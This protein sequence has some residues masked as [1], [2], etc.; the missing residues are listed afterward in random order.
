MIT[1]DRD[2]AA[3]D[4][5][6]ENISRFG[7]TRHLDELHRD[8]YT[9][10]KGA[11]DPET[12]ERART[13]IVRTVEKRT[14]RQIDPM[15]A[16]ADDYRGMDY[17]GYLLF[18]DPVF[19]EI[20]LNPRPLAL[21]TYLLGESC[22]LSSMGSHFR[23]PGGMPL[24]FHADY[25]PGSLMSHI[26]MV[27]NCNYALTPYCQETGALVMT[28]RS[29]LKKRQ[30]TDYEGWTSAGRTQAQIAAAK[31]PAEDLDAV[32]WEAPEGSVTLDIAP[33]DAVVFHGNTW[34]G[35][36][37]RSLPGIRAN[38]AVFMCRSNEVTQEL[39]GDQRYPDVFARHSDNERF[40]RLLGERN[41]NGWR[42]EGPDM[43]GR[44]NL[45]T[46]LYD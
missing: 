36:W 46:G 5:I 16:S 14:G 39:R 29:H 28:P 8:G 21:M 22:V 31:L 18:E 11:L 37:V 7:L 45:P 38:L 26:A 24:P 4:R 44:R 3:Y 30:P 33:G 9:V 27:S 13:A 34:H 42:E 43:S 20:L 41:F 17:I 35:G 19:E 10:L 1:S 15:H 40:S 32:V 25:T 23:G 6:M 12:V 2:A